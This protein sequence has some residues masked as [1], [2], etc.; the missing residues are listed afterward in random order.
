ME[1]SSILDIFIQV[2]IGLFIVIL[3]IRMALS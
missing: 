2:G 3:C 1:H